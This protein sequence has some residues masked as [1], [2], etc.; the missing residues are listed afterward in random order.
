MFSRLHSN[1][2]FTLMEVMITSAC[3]LVVA[4]GFTQAMLV[5]MRTHY[6]SRNYYWATCIA[7]NRLQRAWSMSFDSLGM[8]RETSK[9]VDR[10]GN[11]TSDGRYLRSTIVSNITADSV[12]ISVQV[13]YPGVPGG[14]S[15]VPIEVTTLIKEDM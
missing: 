10:Y 5:A 11:Q 8:M 4:I 9:H 12:W 3:F 13:L 6:L 7:R 2:G 1:E 15:V 14:G